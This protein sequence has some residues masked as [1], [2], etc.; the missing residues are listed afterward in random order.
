[1]QVTDEPYTHEFSVNDFGTNF[2]FKVQLRLGFRVNQRV[3]EYLYQ[4]VETM[5]SQGRLAPQHRRYSI[6]R[7]SGD[8]G[9][10]RFCMIRKMPSASNDISEID[11]TVLGA[12][13]AIRRICGSP[14]EWYGLEN[15]SVIIEY[16]PLFARAKR[17]QKLAYVEI[18]AKI[19]KKNE[20]YHNA[21]ADEDI[22]TETMRDAHQ[23]EE[24]MVAAA[25]IGG[26]T[27]SFRPV[28]M[29]EDGE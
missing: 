8:V 25:V 27:A 11:R 18:P 20:Q 9:D 5:V 17:Q 12:K 26:H 4:I 6:Y 23:Y 10:F 22:F 2:V 19:A 1:V 14:V 21:A 3:N 13:Y 29:E 7:T 15:S 24:E 28:T 16:V